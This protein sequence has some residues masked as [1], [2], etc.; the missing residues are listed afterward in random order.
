MAFERSAS[1]IVADTTCGYHI[2]K[3]DGY[4]RTLGTPPGECLRSRPFNIGGHI[5]HIA[6]YPNTDR[7]RD[8]CKQFISLH[9]D[10]DDNVHKP[11]NA[12]FLF[13]FTC[14]CRG[15]EMTLTQPPPSAWLQS[16]V[17]VFLAQAVGGIRA[18][19]GRW[20]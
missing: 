18:S 19:S 4:S 11:V 6:Y 7:T 1:T 9:L 12:Q 3:I 10:R 17:C 2:L 16:P 13:N 5:W 14:P 8:G 15:P 20:T